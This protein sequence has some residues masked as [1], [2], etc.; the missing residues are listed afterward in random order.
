MLDLSKDY[1]M[2]KEIATRLEY[3]RE[4]NV[5]TIQ[6]VATTR[7]G[8]RRLVA[9]ERFDLDVLTKVD[10]Q[11]A[12]AAFITRFVPETKGQRRVSAD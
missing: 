8:S 10:Y 4:G 6:A 12:R 7:R 2:G 1:L 9:A 3:K 11:R 5:V